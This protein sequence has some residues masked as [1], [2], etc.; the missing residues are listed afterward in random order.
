MK[1]FFASILAGVSLLALVMAITLATAKRAAASDEQRVCANPVP[2]CTSTGCVP[3]VVTCSTDGQQYVARIVTGYSYGECDG[4][5]GK[6]TGY[7]DNFIHCNQTF[8]DQNEQ[9]LCGIASCVVLGTDAG[10]S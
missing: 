2:G 6:C 1:K 8:Y 10:C 9:S 5:I 7:L 3:G 4:A